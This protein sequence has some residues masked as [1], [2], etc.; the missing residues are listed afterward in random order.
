[1]RLCQKHWNKLRKE[2]KDNNLI[3]ANLMIMQ[4]VTEEK[5]EFN[6]IFELQNAVGKEGCPIDYFKKEEWIKRV[7]KELVSQI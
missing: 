7:K 5:T 4:Y 6:S 2:L 3:V 1:M